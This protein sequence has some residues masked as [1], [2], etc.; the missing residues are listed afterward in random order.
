MTMKIKTEHPYI[1]R[2]PGVCGGKPVIQGTRIAVWLI[3]GWFRQGYTP[4]EIQEMYPQ[5]TLAQIHDAL[6]YYYDHQA[7]IERDIREN[8]PSEGE[9]KDL[10][11]AWQR[12][13]ST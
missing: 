1:V 2:I 6:S 8:N 9:L 3:A 5:L 7:E 4:E 11:A 10:Q 13:S 12:L